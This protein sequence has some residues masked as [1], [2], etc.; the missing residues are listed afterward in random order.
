MDFKN[1]SWY[2]KAVIESRLKIRKLTLYQN[3]IFAQNMMFF[4]EMHHVM[5]YS[6]SDRVWVLFSTRF[7]SR[8]TANID[9]FVSETSAQSDTLQLIYYRH[10]INWVFLDWK[11]TGTLSRDTWAYS[12]FMHSLRHTVMAD[13]IL[14]MDGATINVTC[15]EIA[16]RFCEATTAI[17]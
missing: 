1:S 14:T 16:L 9:S 5:L 3:I 8:C 12:P 17:Y 7:S 10:F 15:V 13:I 6:G 2:Q 11:D 4:L